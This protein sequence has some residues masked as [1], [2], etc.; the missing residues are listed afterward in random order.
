VDAL[1]ENRL[2]VELERQAGDMRS[3]AAEQNLI[4]AEMFVERV[5]NWLAFADGN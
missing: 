2:I 5:F 4:E 1:E 3:E